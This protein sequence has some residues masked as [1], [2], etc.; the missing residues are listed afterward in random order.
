M[1]AMIAWLLS[2]QRPKTRSREKDISFLKEKI[3]HLHHVFF[4]FTFQQR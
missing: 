3:M 4:F 2:K 1:A